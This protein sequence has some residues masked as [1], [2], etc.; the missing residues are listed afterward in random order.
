MAH[1]WNGNVRECLQILAPKIP[2]PQEHLHDEGDTCT[3]NWGHICIQLGQWRTSSTLI[4]SSWFISNLL[5]SAMTSD[6][7]YW[8]GGSCALAFC[9]STSF[10]CNYFFLRSFIAHP[11]HRNR[12]H[13]WRTVVHPHPDPLSLFDV[14]K[15][16]LAHA[17]T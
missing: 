15:L 8:S 12:R 1:L 14:R 5:N 16:P 3:C 17:H 6:S 9:A 2:T 10:G 7:R 11:R 4:F 13:S